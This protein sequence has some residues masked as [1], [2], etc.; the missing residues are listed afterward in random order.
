MTPSRGS[1]SADLIE[2]LERATGEDRELNARIWWCVERTRAERA[3]WNAAGG[4]PRALP[5]VFPTNGLGTIAIAMFAPNYS[6]SLDAA[7]S[8]VPEGWSW[9]VT[10]ESEKKSSPAFCGSVRRYWTS[11]DKDHFAFAVSPAIA[12]CIAS[13][14]ARAANVGEDV[15]ALV[16]LRGN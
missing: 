8:L 9:S 4:L 16:R 7:V 6:G 14:R 5:D 3:Y 1:P 13:L 2:R 11:F 15:G 12:L 10:Y